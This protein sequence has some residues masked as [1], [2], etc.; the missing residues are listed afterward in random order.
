M[1]KIIEGEDSLD[2]TPPEDYLDGQI[3]SMIDSIGK[4]WRGTGSGGKM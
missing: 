4:D 2:G 1:I 3:E